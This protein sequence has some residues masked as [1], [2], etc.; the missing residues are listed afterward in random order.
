MLYPLLHNTFIGL[1]CYYFLIFNLPYLVNLPLAFNSYQHTLIMCTVCTVL[2]FVGDLYS[3][4]G[5]ASQHF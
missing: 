1:I 2:A 5:V 3:V 4:S